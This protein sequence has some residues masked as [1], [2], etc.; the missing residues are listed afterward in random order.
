[1][2]VTDFIS[3][4]DEE[5]SEILSA[6]HE[7][8]VRADQKVKAEVGKMM[9]KEMVLYKTGNIFK[10]GLSSVKNHMSL[11]VMPI[12]G[13]TELHSKYKELLVK[14]I[15]QKGCINFRSK[16]EMPLDIVKELLN[17]CA[18]ID[19]TAI[20]ENVKQNPRLNYF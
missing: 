18:K 9:G 4:Q 3:K 1:M 19:M 16:E 5:R 12:Y 7:I 6:I 20:M 14:A 15:F 2:S 11:H 17:D 8:I 13:S 10:Y